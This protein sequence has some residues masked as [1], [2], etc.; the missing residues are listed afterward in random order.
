MPKAEKNE[1]EKKIKEKTEKEKTN[2]LRVAENKVKENKL[3]RDNKD[4]IVNEIQKKSQ[5]IQNQEERKNKILDFMKNEQYV[6][7]KAKEIAVVFNVPK[8]EYEDFRK[9][10]NELETENK[11]EKNKKSKYKLIDS[12][13][14]LTGIFRGNQN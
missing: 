14:F 6:P 10:I 7:M 4:N 11:I 5:S 8:N 13:K 3:K 2:K 9:I 12:S 1:I